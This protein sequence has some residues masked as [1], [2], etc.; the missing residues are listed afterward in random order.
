MI[1]TLI[2][3]HG[4]K[5]KVAKHVMDERGMHSTYIRK[6]DMMEAGRGRSHALE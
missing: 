4:A 6:H 1:S 3:R 2:H 5:F